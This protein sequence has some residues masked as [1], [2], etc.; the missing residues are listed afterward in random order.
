MCM[1]LRFSRSTNH[2]SRQLHHHLCAFPQRALDGDGAFQQVHDAQ[3][4]SHAQTVAFGGAGGITLIELIEEV[5]ERCLGHA[6]AGVGNLDI[7]LLLVGCLF[8][9]DFPIR[10]G[11]L[12]GVR[13]DVVPNDIQHA[14]VRG[15]QNILFQFDLQFK[16]LLFDDDFIFEDGL[17]QLPG[18]VQLLDVQNDFLILQLVQL[19]NVGD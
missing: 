9:A 6:A 1:V 3:N 15:D 10:I 4:Q 7:N 2:P 13:E 5:V 17:R 11:E 8:D 18:K 19:E 14:A 16:L 12:D